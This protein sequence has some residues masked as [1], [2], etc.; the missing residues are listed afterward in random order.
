MV[1]AHGGWP[2]C[3]LLSAIRLASA[4]RRS[5][6]RHALQQALA[7]A[8]PMDC[9]RLFL[10]EPPSILPFVDA[11]SRMRSV[12]PKV[13]A[14]AGKVMAS[15]AQGDR[16]PNATTARQAQTFPS[17]ASQAARLPDLRWSSRSPPREQEVLALLAAG[18]SN[19]EIA[20]KL[21]ITLHAVK[22]HTG[23][24]YGKLGVTSRTQA[25]VRARELHLL[26]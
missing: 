23:N 10:D 16:Q 24:I 2:K 17:F 4:R 22:K 25:I 7:L 13:P 5:Q 18:C 9:I 20:D 26:A 21:V 8:A 6:G 15:A 3:I 12:P 14:F 19:R 1:G 11:I